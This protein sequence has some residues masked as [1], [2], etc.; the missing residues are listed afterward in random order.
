M[1]RPFPKCIQTNRRRLVSAPKP[2][3]PT[4]RWCRP[5]RTL[6]RSSSAT[7]SATPVITSPQPS[8]KGIPC[9][10]ALFS[11]T[12]L[13]SESVTRPCSTMSHLNSKRIRSALA[14]IRQRCGSRSQSESAFDTQ[15]TAAKMIACS[16][17]HEHR[18]ETK[19]SRSRHADYSAVRLDL[20]QLD[21]CHC[22]STSTCCTYRT[23]RYLYSVGKTFYQS[24]LICITIAT[25]TSVVWD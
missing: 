12:T 18:R 7:R 19:G 24:N 3:C 5:L 23:A 14:G 2:R 20:Q 9:C 21:T 16:L 6:D 1:G 13:L 8:G 4:K 22:R 15:L 10:S 11:V 25:C 17:I